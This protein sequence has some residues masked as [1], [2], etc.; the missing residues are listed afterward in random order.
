[1]S[2]RT[3]SDVD[4][5]KKVTGRSVSDKDVS[6]SYST[7]K[8]DIVRAQK[9]TEVVRRDNKAKQGTSTYKANKYGDGAV[10]NAAQAIKERKRMLDDL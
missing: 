9:E 3:Q 8:Q 10:K 5:R 1:M 4:K 6:D 2:D 7:A